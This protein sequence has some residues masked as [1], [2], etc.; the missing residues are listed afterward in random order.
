MK[1]NLLWTAGIAVCIFVSVIVAGPIIEEREKQRWIKSTYPW[2]FSTINASDVRLQILKTDGLDDPTTPRMYPE[3]RYGQAAH[4]SRQEFLTRVKRIP[5]RFRVL[6]RLGNDD[7]DRIQ[8]LEFPQPPLGSDGIYLLT[9]DK[10]LRWT[11]EFDTDV[12]RPLRGASVE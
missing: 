3:G 10:H 9:F 1:K 7:E 6:W 12:F 5:S 11:I 8:E 4:S 2:N